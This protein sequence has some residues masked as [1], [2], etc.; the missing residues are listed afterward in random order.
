VRCDWKMM[1][2]F[3]ERWREGVRGQDENAVEEE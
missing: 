1:I 3:V 2:D